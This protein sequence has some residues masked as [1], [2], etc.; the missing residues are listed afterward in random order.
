[1]QTTHNNLLTSPSCLAFDQEA[2]RILLDRDNGDTC[3]PCQDGHYRVTPEETTWREEKA[4]DSFLCITW[5][6]N[7]FK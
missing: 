1:M 3:H 4:E 7:L 2:Y 5:I 6:R